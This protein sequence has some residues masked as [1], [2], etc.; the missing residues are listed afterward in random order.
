MKFFALF[1]LIGFSTKVAEACSGGG[2]KSD[3]DMPVYG[4]DE[5]SNL[6]ESK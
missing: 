5:N 6:K 4:T 3:K 2:D 1:F